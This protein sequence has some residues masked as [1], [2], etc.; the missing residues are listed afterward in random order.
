MTGTLAL[1]LTS[2]NLNLLNLA[3]SS[4]ALNCVTFEDNP[5]AHSISVTFNGSTYSFA[6]KLENIAG[7]SFGCFLLNG[8]EVLSPIV[9][10]GE[11]TL[12]AG[13][14]KIEFDLSYNENSGS[15]EAIINEST[16]T[17][18]DPDR[19]NDA[20]S[21]AGSTST[22]L[23]GFGGSYKLTCVDE[24]GLDCDQASIPAS[25]FFSPFT[26]GAKKKVAL[27]Q[28]KAKRDQCMKSGG[29]EKPPI[30]SCKLAKMY[31]I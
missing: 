24:V 21:N 25:A 10:S 29:S 12:L 7:I 17:A 6:K 14:G 2:S 3:D 31:Q 23:S 27:W 15:A 16:S 30:S 9:F 8:S 28:S 18:F 20:I 19:I 4:Y 26:I 22:D 13:S 5:V 1:N 11:S